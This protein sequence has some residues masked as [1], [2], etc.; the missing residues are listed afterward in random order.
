MSYSVELA[1][2]GRAK[3][4]RC[5]EPIAKDV[6]RIGQS[7]EMDEHVSTAW[8][9]ID[10]APVPRDQEK[11]DDPSFMEGFA[12]MDEK[13]QEQI[14]THYKEGLKKKAAGKKRTAKKKKD[15]DEDEDESEKEEK[16]PRKKTRRSKKDEEEE[17]ETEEEEE[18]DEALETKKKEINK[19]TAQQLKELCR[20]HEMIQTGTKAELVERVA[21][22]MVHG[23]INRCTQCGGWDKKKKMFVC[24]GY[25][26]DEHFVRCSFKSE[27]VERT[28]WD[29]AAAAPVEHKDKKEKD[30]EEEGEEE[31]DE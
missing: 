27:T 24:K 26:D 10:C 5:K 18:V 9:H 11:R 25:H 30:A 7:H 22:A 17:E 3:C 1:K 12:D 8:Y 28:P 13:I 2:S 23:V 29:E 31:A 14:R 19:R 4:R 16:K 21:D 15:E 20:D 6:P